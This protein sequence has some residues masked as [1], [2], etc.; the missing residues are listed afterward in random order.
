MANPEGNLDLFKQTLLIKPV[1]CGKYIKK[2]CF[3]PQSELHTAE[4]CFSVVL[5]HFFGKFTENFSY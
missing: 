1:K 4:L 3:S 2:T 5:T